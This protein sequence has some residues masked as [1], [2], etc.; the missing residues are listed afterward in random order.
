MDQYLVRFYE[1]RS[2]VTPA[3]ELYRAKKYRMDY[4]LRRDN[5]QN[6]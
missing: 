4:F 5:N 6:S 1:T 2:G 3:Q